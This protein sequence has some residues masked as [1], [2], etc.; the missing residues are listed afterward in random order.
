MHGDHEETMS[1][2]KPTTLLGDR[3]GVVDVRA[4][5]VGARLVRPTPHGPMSVAD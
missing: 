3:R 2:K 1:T 5:D 4:G